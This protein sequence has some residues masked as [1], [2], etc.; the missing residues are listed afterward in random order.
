ML[1][2][3]G[4]WNILWHLVVKMVFWRHILTMPAFLVWW[5]SWK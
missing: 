5:L 2:Q 3:K 1:R 4:F